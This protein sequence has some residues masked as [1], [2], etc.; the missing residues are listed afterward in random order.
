MKLKINLHNFQMTAET[1]AGSLSNGIRIQ[2]D[3]DKWRNDPKSTKRASINSSTKD[4][5]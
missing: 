2:T 3:S 5:S 4:Y 1:F